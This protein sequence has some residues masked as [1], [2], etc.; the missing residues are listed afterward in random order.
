L[1]KQDK[2]TFTFKKEIAQE[3]ASALSID[4]DDVKNRLSV[5]RAM[6]QLGNTPAIANSDGGIKDRYYSVIAEVILSNDKA[7][8]GYIRQDQN[9]FDLDEESV[10]SINN[11]CHFDKNNRE[12]APIN[13]P[14]EWRKFSNRLKN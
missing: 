8:T 7:L 9:N 2:D 4:E 1:A 11:L 14:Q 3:V 5:F 6:E 13:N 12:G 10:V